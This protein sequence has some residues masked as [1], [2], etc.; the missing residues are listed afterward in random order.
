MNL[1]W[2]KNQTVNRVLLIH[3]FGIG[4]ALFITPL[5]RTLKEH[6]VSQIDV[7]LGSRTREIF[8]TNPNIRHIFEWDKSKS[9]D[10]RQKI[11]RFGHLLQLFY[12]I[13]SQHY[14]VT[15]DFSPTGQYAVTSLFFFWI[16]VR[17][18]FN[19]K[20]KGFFLTHKI[21]LPLGFS[22]KPMVEYYLDL[23]RLLKLKP[24]NPKTEFFLRQDDHQA[25]ELFLR[26][27][28]VHSGQLIAA[29][30]P[31]G[32]ESWGKD[33]R[34]K[35]WPVGNFASLVKKI[36]EREKITGTILILGSQ[37]E[38]TLG[39][40]LIKYFDGNGIF[41]LCGQT[42]IR[43]SA[44]LLKRSLFLIA[45]DSGLVHLAHALDVPVISIFGPVNP[46]VY[47]PYPRHEKALAITNEGPACRPCYQRFR[48]QANCSGIECLNDLT[49]EQV[50]QQIVA[51]RF[52]SSVKSGVL[53]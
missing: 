18:G 35:H 40:E 17:V 47:G 3:P 36:F 53:K 21:E 49:A 45:N 28:N 25:A 51:A 6:G 24:E 37:G 38:R 23:I 50:F 26:Q 5:I 9:K 41:N 30:A 43:T 13:W 46:Q 19:F 39:D 16:P 7:L 1:F 34:L 33:A 22:D 29:V 20:Q 12:R 2:F 10:V 32:G 52:L 11:K 4:D 42:S 27:L 14:Q 44:S 48:Y 8:E 31:G 15:F